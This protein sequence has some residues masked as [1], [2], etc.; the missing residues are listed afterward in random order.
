MVLRDQASRQIARFQHWRMGRPDYTIYFGA[1]IG[2]DLLCT[3][4]AHELK[5]RGAGRIVICSRHPGLFEHST[6]IAAVYNYPQIVTGRLARWGYRTLVPQFST[7]DPKTDRDDFPPG[8]MIEIMCRMAGISGEIE[9]RPYLTLTDAER[10]KGQMQENQAVIQSAGLGLMKNKDWFPDRYQAVCDQ[11]AGSLNM[12]QL[13]L[14]SDPPISGALD[15]R[16]NTTLRES[17]AI[18][19]RSRVFIGQVGLLMHLARAVDTRSVIVYGGREDPAVSGY[20]ANENLVGRTP[21]SYCWQRNRCDFGH[22]CMQM[23]A[24]DPVIAAV[25]RVLERAG[26]PLKVG[27]L[28]LDNRAY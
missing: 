12:I 26:S 19:A 4:V 3:A 11:L 18:L 14:A 24:A 10:A 16:G 8:H 2:D 9:L 6:D 22:E 27:G 1:G 21:C 25:R 20:L 28:N 17:A 23:I 13:G 15:L 5:K 7:Y